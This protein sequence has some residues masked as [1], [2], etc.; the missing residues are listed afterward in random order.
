MQ[1]SV[2]KRGPHYEASGLTRPLL[3]LEPPL[4][5]INE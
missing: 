5:L 4:L 1:M 2:G 3:Y